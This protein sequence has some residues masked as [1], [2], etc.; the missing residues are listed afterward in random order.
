MF[1][2][3]YHITQAKNTYRSH[4]SNMNI[5]IDPNIFCP[6][7]L[8]PLF[9]L[10]IHRFIFILEGQR[11]LA[12]HGCQF[13]ILSGGESENVYFTSH[14]E[15]GRVVEVDYCRLFYILGINCRE[16]KRYCYDKTVEFLD[17]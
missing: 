5:V 14:V 7:N 1:A 13:E 15:F 6:F 9:Q 10:L 3:V 16:L 8:A 17:S 11:S 12:M 2:D 4:I